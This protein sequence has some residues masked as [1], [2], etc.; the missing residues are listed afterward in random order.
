MTSL[1]VT[2]VLLVAGTVLFSR[3]EKNFMDTV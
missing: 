1:A 2:L 3:V